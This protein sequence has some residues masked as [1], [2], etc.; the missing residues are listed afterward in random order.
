M[1]GC[2]VDGSLDQS[3]FS[4]PV[5]WIGLYIAAATL[6]CA[7]AMAAD[8]LDGFRHK[9]FWFPSRY[10]SINAASLTV[11]AVA[12]KLSVD[13]NTPMPR[14]QDQLSKLAS[15][16]FICTV[17]GNSMPSLGAMENKE[18]WSNVVALGILVITC[19]VNV[20]IQLGTGVIFEYYKEHGSIMFIMMLLLVIW[21]SAAI[22]VSTKK[23]Y[24]E[25][26]YRKKHEQAL[27]ESR[28]KSCVTM[29]EKLKED[30]MKYGMMAYTCSPQFVAGRSVVC[31]AAGALSLLSTAILAE[32]MVRSYTMPGSF[33]FCTGESDYKW[34]IT[35][36][37]VAQAIAIGVG[38]IAPAFRWFTAIKF[39][40]V[41]RGRHNLNDE[42]KL[43]RYW[44]IRLIEL[45]EG[46]LDLQVRSR[47]CRKLIYCIKDKA[48]DFVISMQKGIVF[49]SK[50][51]RLLSIVFV[52]RVLLL[53]DFCGG[54]SRS[55]SQG[56]MTEED[57]P[58]T[59]TKPDL[60]QYVLYLEGEEALVGVMMRKNWDATEHW[61]KMGSQNQPNNL[62]HLLEETCSTGFGGVARFMTDEVP[63][64]DVEEPPNCWSLPIATLTSIAVASPGIDWALKKKLLRGVREGLVLV[65]FIEDRFAA[66][67][68]LGNLRKAA[69]FICLGID[70]RRTWLDLDLDRISSQHESTR[71]VLKT[72]SEKAKNTVL[73]FKGATNVC[74]RDVTLRWPVKILSA[75]SM[76]RISETMLLECKSI[77]GCEEQTSRE[78][79]NTIKVAI[80][81]IIAAC[82]T[83]LERVISNESTCSAIEVRK[84]SVREASVLLGR[85]MR[86]LEFLSLREVPSLDPD[87]LASIDEWR[88]SESVRSSL[89]RLSST[90][91]SAESSSAASGHGDVFLSIQ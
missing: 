42:F 44:I 78:L 37:L 22:S 25:M 57:E 4:R 12:V 31:T 62:V 84:E 81:D 51:I 91:Q 27:R 60:S 38:T 11:I 76:Y 59:S 77:H 70:L 89:S 64:L 49:G 75:Y 48:L 82:L 24:L 47:H 14:R 29:F 40:C 32:A 46:P 39:R 2:A 23:L 63:S 56:S 1:L 79:F 30:L 66:K 73:D 80:S 45:K 74:L 35:L 15:S 20:C 61:I 72:L 9:K 83:N 58:D 71:E 87:Q 68:D 67:Q 6:L 34:S 65:K 52:S 85:S 5:P 7:A 3:D 33:Q 28:S 41:K 13:L 50:I 86:I 69:D 90:T 19:L 26:K 8:A 17:L 43:E 10:F 55:F 36:V 88:S 54:L 53:R 18:L 16:A 21:C